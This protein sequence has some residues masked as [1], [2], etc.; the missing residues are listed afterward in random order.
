M[1]RED[2]S[3]I[4]SFEETY[5]AIYAL[6]MK[7]E[8]R[9][10]PP[11]NIAAINIDAEDKK[12]LILQISNRQENTESQVEYSRDFLAAAL[13][14]YCRSQSIPISRKA[15]KSVEFKPDS[16]ILRMII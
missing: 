9:R 5:K 10:P 1:P 6:C 11:G 4:F 16:V 2:R 12:R 15:T 14:L 7:K 3:I 13:L 8:I